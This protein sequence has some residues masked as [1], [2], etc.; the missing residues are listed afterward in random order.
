[1]VALG[2]SK[3]AKKDFDEPPQKQVKPSMRCEKP[4]EASSSKKKLD[5]PQPPP[6]S[7]KKTKERIESPVIIDDSL[8]GS[9]AQ[10][11][12][13]APQSPPFAIPDKPR[14]KVKKVREAKG[15]PMAIPARPDPTPSTTRTAQPFPV[16]LNSQ[17]DE[18]TPPM[19][20]SPKRKRDD[21]DRQGSKAGHSKKS[22]N[23]VELLVLE[24]NAKSSAQ[25][26]DRVPEAYKLSPRRSNVP[27]LSEDER[28]A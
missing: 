6:F 15:F 1:M 25:R 16:S 24:K 17:N 5:G 20:T 9:S 23:P 4:S 21:P 26:N 28:D 19:R 22:S 12:L 14:E 27:D 13:P 2:K 8:E 3:S 18:N 10:K 7:S 11:R